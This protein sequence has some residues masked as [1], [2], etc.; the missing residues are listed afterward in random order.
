MILKNSSIPLYWHK[1]QN[2]F[3]DILNPVLIKALTKKEVQYVKI[4]YIDKEHFICIGSILS[5]AR[6]D[7]IVWGSGFVDNNSFCKEVPKKIC[8]VRGPKTRELLI[9][10]GIECPEVYGDPALL[11]PSIYKPLVKKKYKL[12]IIPHYI[13]QNSSWLSKIKNNPEILI[14]DILDKNIFNFI[15]NILSCEKIASSSLHGIIVADAY[16]TPSLWI[17]FSKN[18]LGNGFKFNDYF[19]SVGRKEESPFNIQ[20]TTSILEVLD[21]FKTYKINIDLKELLRTFPF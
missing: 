15:D 5:E 18:I 19:L 11:L 12:G 16:N 8:A 4:K 7:T 17:E 10:Q 21:N 3:G 2:N 1:K 14:I 6:K 13:D 20:T 9:K